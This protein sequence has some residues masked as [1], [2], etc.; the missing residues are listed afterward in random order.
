MNSPILLNNLRGP[1]LF[2]ALFL[3]FLFLHF[4]WQSLTG[5]SR[6]YLLIYVFLELGAKM[7]EDGSFLFYGTRWLR[8][9]FILRVLNKVSWELRR[10]DK[11]YRGSMH[12][13]VLMLGEKSIQE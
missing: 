12:A 2:P 4:L 3:C 11:H 10:L 1:R 7:L 6:T 9:R 13:S 8:L 5:S